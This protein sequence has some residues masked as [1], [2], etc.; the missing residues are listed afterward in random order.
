MRNEANLGKDKNREGW[1]EVDGINVTMNSEIV[2]WLQE[3][4]YLGAVINDDWDMYR[5][6]DHRIRMVSKMIGAI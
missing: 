2:Q 3:M 6:V 4:K 5:E 1:K